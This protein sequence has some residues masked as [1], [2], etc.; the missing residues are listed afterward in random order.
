MLDVNVLVY[1]FREDSAHHS[2]GMF[3][4]NALLAA[5]A[6]RPFALSELV[7]SGFI[8]TATHPKVF[9]PPSPLG[10]AIE[11]ADAVRGASNCVIVRQG[12]NQWTIFTDLCRKTSAT[13]NDV[14]DA[15]HA[16]LAI[17]SGCEWITSD[18]GFKR[19]PGLR[20]S[21][22]LDPTFKP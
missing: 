14:P 9:S 18:K 17:E 16:A 2:L 6:D 22:L 4:V 1:A 11:F 15:Y 21:Y 12:P 19:F 13:G 7:L 5:A 10:R 8:R 3:V 20:W